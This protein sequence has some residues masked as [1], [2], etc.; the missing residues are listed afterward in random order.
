[1]E[2]KSKISPIAG[3]VQDVG[4]VVINWLSIYSEILAWYLVSGYN[5]S[6]IWAADR[7]IKH[8]YMI[9]L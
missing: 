1:M 7:N 4:S 3:G 5:I 6:I 9:I 8:N 2:Y